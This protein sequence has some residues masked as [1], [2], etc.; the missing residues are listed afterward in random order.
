MADAKEIKAQMLEGYKQEAISKRADLERLMQLAEEFSAYLES[1]EKVLKGQMAAE[2]FEAEHLLVKEEMES[3]EHRFLEF[4][5]GSQ[6]WHRPT[7]SLMFD[8]L[9]WRRAEPKAFKSEVF[10]A[11]LR[12]DRLIRQRLRELTVLDQR[13]ASLT[14]NDTAHAITGV[15]QSHKGAIGKRIR[16]WDE[17]TESAMNI[18]GRVVKVFP[19]IS[20]GLEELAKWAG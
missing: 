6:E 16:N 10:Q 5:E 15:D 7:A 3:E 13:I 19:A 12:F 8:P 11:S 18:G 2:D 17:A 20:K 4:Y 14:D 1:L 9:D